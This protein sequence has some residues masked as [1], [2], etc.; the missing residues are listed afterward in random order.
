[1]KIEQLKLTNGKW[2]MN[3]VSI[4]P[5]L[6]LLFGS[7]L[8]IETHF[9]AI[10]DLQKKYPNSEIVTT[11][12]AGNIID[13]QLLD[14]TIIATCIEFE[15]TTLKTGSFILGEEPDETLGKKIASHFNS[16]D[17]SYLMILSN[18]GIN[19][20]NIIKGV[21][22]VLKDTVTVSGGVAGDD[23]RFEKTLVGINNNITNN[24][25][26]GIA[27]YGKHLNVSHGC[28]GGW[29][30][31]GPIR[32]I[33]K[34]KGN[35]LYEIDHKPALDLYKEYLGDKSKELPSAGSL[36]PF[37]IIDNNTKEPV[38]RGIQNIDENSNSLILYG[39]VEEGQKIQ[40]MR[41][42]FNNLL[43]GAGE[44]ARETFLK[45]TEEPELAIL[46]SCVARRLVLGQLTEEELSETKK[47]LGNTT[48]ICGF[49]SYTELSPLV[50]NNACHIHN[51]TMTI[52]TL[53]EA[54][55]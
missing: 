34:C 51:Q 24:Q 41:A 42:N 7:R 44:S 30:S 5:Q 9:A 20:G 39:D 45:N 38:V 54:L 27:F 31:F 29:D 15:K 50:G 16:E 43:K 26:V 4:Q 3:T 23:N 48:K 46:I 32:K 8:T 37:T 12:S 14:D 1:M 47:V 28:K 6:C 2:E 35:I 49:Y 33:T 11:S 21:N 52:T 25:L 53:T 10:G 13:D 19:A 36:F 18:M 55:G 22:Q 40:L 17:L